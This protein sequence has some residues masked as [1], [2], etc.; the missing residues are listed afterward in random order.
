[1]VSFP[2]W[3]LWSVQSGNAAC[4]DGTLP[5]SWKCVLGRSTH[6]CRSK[7]LS[8]LSKEREITQSYGWFKTQVGWWETYLSFLSGSV[9]VDLNSLCSVLFIGVIA[10]K[11]SELPDRRQNLQALQLGWRSPTLQELQDVAV[12]SQVSFV[13]SPVFCI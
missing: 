13:P 2:A 5:G 6:S 10:V 7:W 3:C 12:E 11:T 8:L 4:A 9:W 1:M